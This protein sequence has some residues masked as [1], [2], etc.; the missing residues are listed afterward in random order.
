MIGALLERLGSFEA[1]LRR[2]RAVNV[3]DDDTKEMAIAIATSYFSACRPHLTEVLS[4]SEPLLEHDEK[5]QQLIRLAHG[6]NARATYRRRVRELKKGLIELNVEYLAGLSTRGVDGHGLSDLAP[7]ENLIIKTLEEFVPSAAAS[8]RQGLLDLQGGERLSYRGTAS[9]FREALRETL[10]HLA[11]DA[12]VQSGPG[13]TVEPGQTKPTMKQKVRFVLG[14][15]GRKRT[16]Q[17]AAEESVDLIEELAGALTRAVYNRASLAT[18]LESSRAEV[19]QIK[20][21][22][23]TVFFDLLE[24]SE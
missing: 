1:R 9:E 3:N 16:Q 19:Q 10:D 5:W 18:H 17:Q 24:I 12:D 7:E 15:R 23:D 2:G 11:P 14:S 13:Y 22:I 21:Y 20:R 4:E 8:Y 6:N